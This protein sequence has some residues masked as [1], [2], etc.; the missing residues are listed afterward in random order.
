MSIKIPWQ[1]WACAG[2][3]LFL[4]LFGWYWDSHGASRVQKRWDAAVARGTVI[5]AGL[6]AEQGKVTVRVETKYVDRWK[7]IHEKGDT[8]TK[9]VP[10]FIS[11]GTCDLPG[12]FRVLHDAA[13]SGT[14]PSA[15]DLTNAE[16]VPASTAAT[17]VTENYTT[18][19]KAI[20]DLAGLREWL[21]EQRKVY[22]E[23]CKL[24]GVD[25]SKDN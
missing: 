9:L 19:N 22:L 14:T 6:K 20:S 21:E 23:R 13:V 1:V 4:V 15:A 3:G 11:D 24:P 17:T 5:V 18:C 2:L 8:I 16:P 7:V 25:C 10:Q 12:G